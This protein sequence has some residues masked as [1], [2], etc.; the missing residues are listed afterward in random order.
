MTPRRV[1]RT[2]QRREVGRPRHR[3]SV[4]TS[5]VLPPELRNP[6]VQEPSCSSRLQ[7]ELRMHLASPPRLPSA[8]CSSS[9]CD[10]AA[11]SLHSWI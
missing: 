9:A 8:I 7:R 4:R 6:K 11:G 5:R 2:R 10:V 3:A 1:C